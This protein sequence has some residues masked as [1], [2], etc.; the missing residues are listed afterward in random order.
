MSTGTIL[1]YAIIIYVLGLL[2]GMFCIPLIIEIIF[3][4]DEERK[5]DENGN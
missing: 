1:F 2:S 4:N 3:G 5:V